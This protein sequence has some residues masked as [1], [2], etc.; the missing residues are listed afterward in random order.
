MHYFAPTASASSNVKQEVNQSEVTFHNNVGVASCD[1][2]SRIF[3]PI[4]DVIQSECIRMLFILEYGIIQTTN[5]F[6]AWYCDVHDCILKTNILVY[7]VP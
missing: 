4:C 5:T 6:A 3:N 1:S 7:C 2:L